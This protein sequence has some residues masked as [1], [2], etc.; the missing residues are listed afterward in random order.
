MNTL[1]KVTLLVSLVTA[2]LFLAYEHR[3]HIFGNLSYVFF[4][5]F[6]G[7]HLLMHLGHGGHGSH[8]NNKEKGEHHHE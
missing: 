1:V 4:A 8:G 2:G 3:I 5:V 7:M 6:I